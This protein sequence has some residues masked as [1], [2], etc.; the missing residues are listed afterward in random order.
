MTGSIRKRDALFR[1]RILWISS[2]FVIALPLFL[3]A[4]SIFGMDIVNAPAV[5]PEVPHFQF[6]QQAQ[7]HCPDDA[8]VWA[9]GRLGIYN[10]NVERWYGHT[11]DGTFTCLQDVQKAG[12]RATRV[13]P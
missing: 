12:Y 8:I 2:P 7:Q 1:W 13:V 4:Q 3:G 11:G 10:S 9:I 5:L 6:E